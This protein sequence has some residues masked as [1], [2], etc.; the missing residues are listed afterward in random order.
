MPWYMQ[1][2]RSSSGMLPPF[3]ARVRKSPLDSDLVGTSL[4]YRPC[5]GVL[6]SGG[7]PQGHDPGNWCESSIA[8]IFVFF[9]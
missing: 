3:S 8:L 1:H 7:H 4:K 6:V 5:A 9:P 2:N